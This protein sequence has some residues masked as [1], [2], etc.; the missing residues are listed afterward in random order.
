MLFLVALGAFLG[1]GV[2]ASVVGILPGDLDVRAGLVIPDHSTWRTVAWTVNWAGTWRVLLP[3]SLIVYAL[4]PVARR[5]WWLWAA[6]FLASGAVEQGVKYLVARPRPS[7]FSLGFPSGHTTAAAVFAVGLVYVLSRA[8]LGTGARLAA[9]CAAVAGML[10]VGWARI[11]LRAHWPTD[12][13]GGLLLGAACAAA[14]AW[15]DAARDVEP[16]SRP[17]EDDRPMA[18]A[19]LARS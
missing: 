15:W 17:A 1:M 7:G 6:A 4:S 3:A 12:V 11:V 16:P 18:R 5:R 19:G 2:A 14:V 10:L 8:R 9:Q 13:L